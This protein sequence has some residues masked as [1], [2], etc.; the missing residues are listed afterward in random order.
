MTTSISPPSGKDAERDRRLRR[1]YGITVEQYEALLSEQN[2]VCAV[3]GRPPKNV[4][5]AV[6]HDHR[7]ERQ[8]GAIHVR[9]LLCMM[10]NRKIVGVIE[11]LRVDPQRVAD[12][13]NR[14]AVYVSERPTTKTRSR[15]AHKRRRYR[16]SR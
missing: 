1:K 8:T 3:C 16:K 6:D 14:P 7:V 13:L 5:H 15:G 2:G 12:Y 11:R 9:G 10:C 4:R